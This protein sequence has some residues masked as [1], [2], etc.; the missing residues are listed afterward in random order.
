MLGLL[1][2]AEGGV[3]VGDSEFVQTLR[4]AV[5]APRGAKGGGAEGERGVESRA[6]FSVAG[7]AAVVEAQ[8]G[9]QDEPG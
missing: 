8:A 3:A 1:G 5:D 2:A 6:K 4:L 9:L 7:A